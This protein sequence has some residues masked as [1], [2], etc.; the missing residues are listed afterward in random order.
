MRGGL[1]FGSDNELDYTVMIM[2]RMGLIQRVVL[3]SKHSSS[4]A[5]SIQFQDYGCLLHVSV[6]GSMKWD[7]SVVCSY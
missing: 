2:I 1:F 4:N 5:G 6:D 7:R 3:V